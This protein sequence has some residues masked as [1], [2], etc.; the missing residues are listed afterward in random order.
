M[1]RALT[2][3]KIGADVKTET[4]NNML[5]S[6]FTKV[7]ADNVL[8]KAA[9]KAKEDWDMQ[10]ENMMPINNMSS[11]IPQFGSGGPFKNYDELSGFA[12]APSMNFD[13][14]DVK[15]WYNPEDGQ[16]HV[17]TVGD[18]E[19]ANKFF[20]SNG[21]NQT[22]I[23]DLANLYSISKG[24]DNKFKLSQYQPPSEAS[25]K[26]Y[27]WTS[28]EVQ[29]TANPNAPATQQK[30]G[31]NPFG[32][33]DA[34]G[35]PIGFGNGNMKM[36]FDSGAKIKVNPFTGNVRMNDKFLAG[37]FNPDGTPIA[38]PNLGRLK[39]AKGL[40]IQNMNALNLMR[41]NQ[42][43]EL[44]TEQDGGLIYDWRT[45]AMLANNILNPL[46]RGI[47]RLGDKMEEENEWAN[48]INDSSRMQNVHSVSS[49]YFTD[50]FGNE[51]YGEYN[52]YAIGRK[53]CLVKKKK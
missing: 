26:D 33:T 30:A 12:S 28:P 31:R 35:I 40:N 48:S 3:R 45:D 14:G 1:E 41:G 8:R 53:G 20:Y 25:W 46:N 10:S 51:G 24:E 42:Q 43:Q 7:I 29:G 6:K 21:V 34:P 32:E 44:K 38:N 13:S 2:K 23:S 50:N 36:K 9:E 39:R 22:E 17:V 5:R 52:P 15:I 49:G 27:E 16:R 4:Y 47:N 18:G 11:D 37:A 19:N